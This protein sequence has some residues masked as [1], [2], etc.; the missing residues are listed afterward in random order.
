MEMENDETNL[1]KK[2]ISEKRK[3]SDSGK[4]KEKRQSVVNFKLT[5]IPIHFLLFFY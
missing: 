4:G 2:D 1:Q 3:E 5:V